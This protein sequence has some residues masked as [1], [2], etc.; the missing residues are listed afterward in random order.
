MFEKK[1]FLPTLSKQFGVMIILSSI[2]LLA[3]AC[4]SSAAPSANPAVVQVN[5]VP[6]AEPVSV[7]TQVA[8]PAQVSTP[9]IPSSNY[10]GACTVLT[11]DDVSKVLG[12]SVDTVVES[13]PSGMCTYTSKNLSIDFLIAGHT[14]GKK[15]MATTLTR[16]GD[17][18]LVVPGLGDQAYYNTNPDGPGALFLLKGDAEYNFSMSDLNYQPLDPTFKQATEKA[19]A[20]QLLSKSQ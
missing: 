17:L 14:G 1:K 2:V 8:A 7:P 6:T 11:K 3:A 10:P 9:A 18:A 20:V 16:L 13:N 19:L 12:A 4:A 5:T 15:A